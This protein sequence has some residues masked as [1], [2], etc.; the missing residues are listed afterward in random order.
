MSVPTVK[1][2]EAM[3]LP[4]LQSIRVYAEGN[5]KAGWDLIAECWTDED[6]IR[7]LDGTEKFSKAITKLGV[8]VTIHKNYAYEIENA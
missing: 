5:A 7:Y 1:S 6:I 4:L 2:V 3:N 8:V